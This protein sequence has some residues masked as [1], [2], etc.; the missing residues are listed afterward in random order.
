[1][2]LGWWTGLG[3]LA[4]SQDLGCRLGDLS[5]ELIEFLLDDFFVIGKVG[6]EPFEGTSVILSLKIAL[7][8][9]QLIIAHL[10]SQTDT[11]PHL[12]RFIDMLEQAVLFGVGKRAQTDFLQQGIVYLKHKAIIPLQLALYGLPGEDVDAVALL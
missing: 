1:L 10:I 8:L 4:A 2:R 5:L 9:V 3:G 12:K 7:K 11:D 6:L